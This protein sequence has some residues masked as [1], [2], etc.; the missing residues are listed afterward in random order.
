MNIIIGLSNFSFQYQEFNCFQQIREQLNK[1]KLLKNQF[2]QHGVSLSIANDLLQNQYFGQPL[3]IQFNNFEFGKDRQVII[4]FR[5]KF[6]REFSGFNRQY[7]SEE[8]KTLASSP[9]S[10]DQICYTLYTPKEDLP[11]I[12][13]FKTAKE[14]SLYFEYILGRYPVNEESYYQRA[15]SHFTNVIYHNDCK[16]TLNQVSDGFCNYSIAITKC[17]HAL[18]SLSPLSGKNIQNHLASIAAKA[19]YDCTVQ[20]GSHQ[21]FKFPFEYNGVTYPSLNCEYHLK[22]SDRN[23]SGDTSYHHKRIYFG[24]IPFDEDKLKIAIAVIG[25]HIT[26]IDL[27]DRYAPERKKKT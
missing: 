24:F 21:N 19:N 17:L 11:N 27:N 13:N 10:I 14:F 15:T 26:T 2:T 5:A 16:E 1:L 20:G 25:P 8:L 23:T 12:T 4:A 6:E 3:E 9:D 22:P 7:T 18:N